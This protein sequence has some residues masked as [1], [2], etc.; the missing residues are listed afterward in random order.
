[1]DLS[2]VSRL[3]QS[4]SPKLQALALVICFFTFLPSVF[5]V[6]GDQTLTVWQRLE[7]LST[8]MGQTL[9]TVAAL[10]VDPRVL[11]DSVNP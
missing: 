4:R 11:D 9:V 7:Q 10:A 2:S 5:R 8:A 1:M 6:C 3:F